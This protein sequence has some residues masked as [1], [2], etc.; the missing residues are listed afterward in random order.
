M[1]YIRGNAG[2]YNGWALMGNTGWSYGDVL[3]Y[4][5]KA[6][7]NADLVDDFH[8]RD[9]PLS[10]ETPRHRV[11]LCELFVEAAKEMGLPFNPASMVRPKPDAASCRRPSATG[12]GPARQRPI[13][14]R[15]ATAPT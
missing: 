1:V 2:D 13:S 5:R 9:G 15:S 11:A 6:E 8:G 10:V 3:P 7:S 14:S 4:F 12:A